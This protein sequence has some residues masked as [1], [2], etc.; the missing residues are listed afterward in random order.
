VS[1]PADRV[2]LLCYQYD[3]ATGRYTVSV[4]KAVR[5]ASGVAVASL[6]GLVGGLWWRGRRRAA[7]APRPG[8]QEG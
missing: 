2:L 3:P 7:T 4:L 5:L 8:G 6:A 1:A